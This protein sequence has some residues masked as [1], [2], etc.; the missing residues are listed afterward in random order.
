MNIMN[1]I[2][3][4]QF[5]KI[6]IG[7]ETYNSDILLFQDRVLDNWHREKGH[8]LNI[9]DLEDVIAFRPDILI[10]GNGM[11]GLMHVNNKIINI[12]KEKGIKKVLVLRTKKACE[13]YNKE[14]SNKKA[15]A[16]HI[17]C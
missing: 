13:E 6:N 11:Y 12:L 15:A 8:L 16:L 7:E 1:I 5:G 9:K 4:C 2:K 3:N 14:K 10:I 17:T